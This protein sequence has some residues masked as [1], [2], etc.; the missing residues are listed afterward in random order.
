MR[1]GLSADPRS[2]RAR[3]IRIGAARACRCLAVDRRRRRS[4]KPEDWTAPVDHAERAGGA[5][6]P[7]A[8]PRRSASWLERGEI[9]EGKGKRAD[10]RR[11]PGAGAQARPLRPCAVAQPEGRSD[12]PVAGA[13]RL[14]AD[15]PYR[16]QGSDGARPLPAAAGGRS[17]AGRLLK[18]PLFGLGEETLFELAAAARRRSH[19]RSLQPLRAEA[20]DDLRLRDASTSS[21]AG[22]TEAA[23]QP[24]FEFYARCSAATA[25]GGR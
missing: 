3:S 25:C 13:D 1:R 22:L 5:A 17:V 21:T 6:W 7:S 10:G 19:E 11:H 14:S 24:V 8:S 9:I 4:T 2:G 20:T 23:F 18:S 15:R 16:R 12:I